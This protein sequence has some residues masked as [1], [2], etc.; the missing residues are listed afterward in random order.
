MTRH[1]GNAAISSRAFSRVIFLSNWAL[2]EIEWAVRTGTRTV[3]QV[4]RKSG[5]PMILRPSFVIFISS[6]VYPF[7]RNA[8]MCG[9]T[10][11]AIWWLNADPPFPVPG[12]RFAVDLGHHQ[13]DVQL[14]P[15]GRRV[16]DDHRTGLPGR[17]SEFLAPGRSRGEQGDVD[18]PERVL[19]KKLDGDLLPAESYRFPDRPLG[20]KQ[21][22][23]PYGE[24]PLLQ[25]GKHHFSDR[26]GGTR[27]P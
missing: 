1:P 3:V 18:S 6:F 20:S 19:R 15:E 17:R 7:S 12:N 10:L 4:T 8:S 27:A 14:H 26:A 21:A 13:G 11:K 2:T 5:I 23:V 9:M 24:P 22:D 16:V 25:D